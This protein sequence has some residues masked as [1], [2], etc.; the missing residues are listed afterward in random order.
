MAAAFCTKKWLNAIA[1]ATTVNASN[2]INFCSSSHKFSFLNST[3][4]VSL[5]EL[6]VSLTFHH[7][8]LEGGINMK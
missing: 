4:P 6:L 3:G 2:R 5:V 1:T 7:S 8:E